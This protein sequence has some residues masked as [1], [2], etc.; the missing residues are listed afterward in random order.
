MKAI[1]V[2]DTGGPESLILET[3]PDPVP[4]PRD[5]LIEVAACGVCTHDVVVRNGVFRRGVQMPLIPGHEVSGV[6]RAIGLDVRSFAI[7]DRVA[8]VQRSHVCGACGYCRTGRET[9]CPDQI[10]LGDQG[11]NGGYADYVLVEEDNLAR[12]PDGVDLQSASIVA[13]TIGTVLN[14]IRDVGC[15]RPGETVLVTG[16]GGGLGAHA[17]QVAKLAGARVLAQTTTP[18]KADLIRALGVEE[19]VLTERGTDFSG[20]VKDLTAGVG[21]DVVVDTVGTPVFR[22]VLRSMAPGARWLLIGQLT[23]DFVQ[24][25]PAQLFSRGISMLSAVSTTRKQL[26]DCLELVARGDLKP[27]I[28]RLMPLSEAALA[29]KAVEAGSS[30]GRLVLTPNPGT[31]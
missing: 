10:F 21:V 30:F 27:I 14:G 15:V 22:S 8:S 13:C 4:G 20:L 26:Q 19:V 28:E 16:S 3:V 6:V 5:V 17:V 18:A 31:S 29:H 24:F 7:G 12:V 2:R 1:V 11:L 23:G 25:N 9:I